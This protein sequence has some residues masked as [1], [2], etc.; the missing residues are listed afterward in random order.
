[1]QA[2]LRMQRSADVSYGIRQMEPLFHFMIELGNVLMVYR[3]NQGYVL[4]FHDLWAASISQLLL[5]DATT[6]TRAFGTQEDGLS[7][8]R[9]TAV[10]RL[11]VTITPCR[12]GRLRG[13]TPA[14]GGWLGHSAFSALP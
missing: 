11:S 10:D 9:G 2:A 12:G 4:V 5:L 6:L 13:D 3:K 14:A 8:R 7:H 1:M